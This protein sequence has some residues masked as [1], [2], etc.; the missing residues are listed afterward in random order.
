MRVLIVDDNEDDAELLLRELR[1]GGLAPASRR[2]TTADELRAALDEPWDVV[3]SDWSMPGFDGLAAYRI[4]RER[5][6]DLPFIIASGTVDEEIA[7]AALKA[8][9]HDFV[10]K[11]KLTRLVPAIE[12]EIREAAIRRERHA[13]G[14]ELERQRELVARGED[15]YRAMFDSSPLPMW[16]F[17]RDTLAFVSVND[18][19]VRH[20]GYSREEFLAMTLADIR[21]TDDVEA[22]RAEVQR[23]R[24]L[25]DHQVWRHRKKD[26]SLIAV[27]VRAN[28]L[29]LDGKRVR[30]ALI[31]DVTEREQPSRRPVTLWIATLALIAVAVLNALGTDRLVTTM[32]RIDHTH[33]LIEALDTVALRFDEGGD[34]RAA[35]ATVHDELAVDLTTNDTAQLERFASLEAAVAARSRP[36]VEQLL[37]TMIGN[38]R[39][40][41]ESQEA[42]TARQVLYERIT[43]LA[44]TFISLTLLWLV[45]SRLSREARLRRAAE[46]SSRQREESLATMLHSIGDGVIATDTDGKVLRMNRVAEELTGWTMGEAIGR[47]FTDVFRIIDARTR[48]PASDPVARVLGEGV[49]VA[50]EDHTVL[51]ARDGREIPIADSAA[52]ILD[53]RD[54]TAGAVLVFR[55]ASAEREYADRLRGLN[56]EL[57]RRVEERTRALQTTEAQLQQSQ[58]MEAIGRLAGGIAHDFNNLL[59]V[60]ISFSEMLIEDA[61]RAHLPPNVTADLEEIKKAGMRAADLTRQLLA[62]SRQQ[63]LA[64]KLVDLNDIVAGMEKLLRRVIGADIT[65]RVVR[66]SDGVKVKVDPGQIEQVIM[67]LGVNARDAMPTGGKLTIDVSRTV[68]DDEFAA[69][70]PGIAPGPYVQLAVTDTGTGM[71]KEVQAQIFEPFFTTKEKGKGTGL[72]LSTVFGIVQQSGGTVWVYSELGAGTTFKIYLPVAQEAVADTTVPAPSAR[73]RGSETILLVEDEPGVRAIACGILTRAGYKVLEAEDGAAALRLCDATREPIH[74]VLTDVVMPGMSGRELVEQLAHHRPDAKVLFMSGYT[75]DTVVH[76]GVLDQGIAFLQ[77]PIMPDALTKKVR[78]VLD[79]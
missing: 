48:E 24:G 6:P 15:R 76:H 25:S 31:T 16:T 47:P 40:T 73:P 64:P 9:V 46:E 75:D 43:Q 72:G 44:A 39:R 20:Y 49:P 19:A 78:E 62:F 35:L 79:S 22:L 69:Q 77:K 17:D 45:F 42:T 34:V 55:D 27:E 4:V 41:L 32:Q 38:A 68:L 61:D 14:H 3:I 36:D 71:S 13:T 67:N 23:A 18:A 57:E 59:S 66:S 70:H 12:R 2:V 10:G 29:V 65:L 56:E 5:D 53:A 8:G 74:L 1:R 33:R 21:P 11:N 7:V 50:L 26:G 37:Q 51:I 54:Q 60:I 30:L 63:V 52:P 58:K 28:D